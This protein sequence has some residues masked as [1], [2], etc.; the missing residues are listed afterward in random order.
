MNSIMGLQRQVA[1]LSAAR[2]AL[3]NQSPPD[4]VAVA[5]VTTDL[6]RLTDA[7]TGQIDA[8]STATD[9]PAATAAL[10]AAI[11]QLNAE[12]QASAGA[13]ELLASVATIA[14]L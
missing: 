4:E 12:M 1:A 9:P 8:Q 3:Q 14:S 5:Q 10:G 6:I 7:L 13:D 11:A 2:K